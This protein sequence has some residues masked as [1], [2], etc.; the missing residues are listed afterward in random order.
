MEIPLGEFTNRNKYLLLFL[1]IAEHCWFSETKGF[2]SVEILGQTAAVIPLLRNLLPGRPLP[3]NTHRRQRKHYVPFK[4]HTHTERVQVALEFPHWT[5]SITKTTSLSFPKSKPPL[6][7]GQVINKC[8]T[9][10]HAYKQTHTGKK[11]PQ[12]CEEM[13]VDT[14]EIA[15]ELKKRKSWFWWS[16]CIAKRL[17]GIWRQLLAQRIQKF[18]NKITL[19]V[20][21][22][23]S[24][25]LI[26]QE[27]I[28]GFFERL[29]HK[30]QKIN[31]LH[32]YPW[33]FVDIFWA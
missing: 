25:G 9:H 20:S 8:L 33:V 4:R 32:L 27:E 29:V 6:S 21:N 14:R 11:Q 5:L 2:R 13:S 16:H 17:F 10:P 31:S 22:F 3:Q 7:C 12:T 19:L 1:F 30:F 15:E 18:C 23:N 26:L 28:S 24:P